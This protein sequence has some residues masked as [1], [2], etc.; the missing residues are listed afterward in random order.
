MGHGLI[1]LVVAMAFWLSPGQHRRQPIIKPRYAWILG[2]LWVSHLL[3]A[4]ALADC[5]C[6]YLSTIGDSEHAL[7]T[8]LLETDFARV[9]DIAKDTDW[10]R[11]AF[12]LTEERARGDH[13]EMFAVE[14]VFGY[15]DDGGEEGGT[16]EAESWNGE[17]SR[18][19]KLL[20]GSRL[21]DGM[22]PVAE[23]D[24]QRLDIFWGTF[25]ASMKLTDVPGTCAAF[26]WYFNDTQEIDMEF[27]SR[28]FSPLN[29]SYPVNL[30]LQS[31]AA[32][33][34]GHDASRTDAFAKAY[35]PFDPT[36]AFHEYRIDYL[37]DRVLFYA[38][39]ALLAEMRDRGGG[40]VP[41]AA[42]HLILQH[43][44]NGNR[45]WSGGP[46]PRDSA[47][48]VRYVKAYFNSSAARRQRDWEGR[49]A[50]PRLEKA[51]CK[52]PDVTPTDAGAAGWFFRDQKNM[53]N[54]QT[55]SR[56]EGE[57]D[58]DDVGGAVRPWWEAMG[59]LVAV[60]ALVIA[61]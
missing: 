19:L 26:F 36:A 9:D 35:L 52:I 56:G 41:S 61:L 17:R 18:G 23:I 27:L 40:A 6:G 58:V 60:S 50:D 47:L 7:F 39:G 32:A 30:V 4:P 24:T 54:N 44:S 25:R 49:C 28:E 1:A 37:R 20:V 45:Y 34:A 46:P 21:V 51:V 42:G 59:L 16:S 22:V 11:Q 57:E 2:L 10:V 43:W 38:D 14:N 15:H 33:V 5:E 55:I 8:D 31:R 13:G 12:N 48:T 29:G 3:L 53:T